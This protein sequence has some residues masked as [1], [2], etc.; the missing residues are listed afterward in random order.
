MTFHES[1]S[2]KK[3]TD[4]HAITSNL[5]FSNNDYEQFH[6]IPWNSMELGVRQCQW[7]EQ[8]HRIPWNS[9]E[10]GVRQFRWH[11][12]FH[13]IPWNLLIVNYAG[14]S[15]SME[16]YGIPWNLKWANFDDMSIIM[17]HLLLLFVSR[18]YV[19][20]CMLQRIGFRSSDTYVQYRYGDGVA[21]GCVVEL[22]GGL[23]HITIIGYVNKL[24]TLVALL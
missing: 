20:T 21:Q 13:G 23:V 4:I 3:N 12:Q 19:C 7:H 14:T 17:V 9:M 11:T 24:T 22:G 10:L 18:I 6:G 1:V 2:L 8:F 16:F 5:E 15:S